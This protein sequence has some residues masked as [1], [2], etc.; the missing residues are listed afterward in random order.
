MW[1]VVPVGRPTRIAS[2]ACVV[3]L[4]FPFAGVVQGA[5]DDTA[6]VFTPPPFRVGERAEYESPGNLTFVVGPAE[7]IL[8]KAGRPVSTFVIE[9]NSH[10]PI[11]FSVSFS[12]G[13][14]ERMDYPCT[15]KTAGGCSPWAQWDWTVQGAPGGLGAT[16][17][18]GRTFSIGSSWTINGSCAAC[19][20]PAI[21]VSIHPPDETS[22]PGTAY[23]ANISASL[24]PRTYQAPAGVIHMGEGTAFPLKAVLHNRTYVLKKH[25]EGGAPHVVVSPTPSTYPVS[26]NVRPWVDGYPQEGE[27][28]PDHMTLADAL[29]ATGDGGP[30]DGALLLLDY[31]WRTFYTVLDPALPPIVLEHASEWEVRL[32]RPGQMDVLRTYEF[33]RPFPETVIGEIHPGE[34]SRTEEYL[35]PSVTRACVTSTIP[36]WDGVR[37]V[38]DL[39]VLPE[40]R[41]FTLHSVD[42]SLYRLY[43]WG[44]THGFT[45]EG[46]SMDP[47]TGFLTFGYVWDD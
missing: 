3:G 25:V 42:C 6:V 32:A 26:D 22:P 12:S 46:I 45:S 7:T 28:L 36:L 15:Q 18:Q 21:E 43:T 23:V 2:L 31:D 37:Q 20:S 9:E 8:D 34:W 1:G 41:G 4:A 33:T 14:V 17:L 40:F 5:P 39:G 27:P 10:T 38:L 44:P 47:T 24:R 11:I 13:L 16:I 29:E 19:R 35:T 30:A